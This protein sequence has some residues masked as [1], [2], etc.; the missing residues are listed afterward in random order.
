VLRLALLLLMQHQSSWQMTQQLQQPQQCHQV[1]RRHCHYP[2]QAAQQ[3][4]QLLP[5]RGCLPALQQVQQQLVN[6][7]VSCSGVA[8]CLLPALCQTLLLLLQLPAWGSY[9]EGR[10][11]Q[12]ALLVLLTC[13]SWG[14]LQRWQ[15]QWVALPA[16][17]QLRQTSLHSL[18]RQA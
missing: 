2:C 8:L 11:R 13:L 16:S 7:C 14:P 4:Q 9:L 5:Q 3:Q 18:Q 10:Q 17:R 6:C 12:A 1:C 15:Q